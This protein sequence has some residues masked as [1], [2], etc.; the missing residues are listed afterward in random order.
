ML[1]Q[2]TERHELPALKERGFTGYLIKP[3]RAA[4]LA[5]RLTAEDAFEDMF[6]DLPAEI[7]TAAGWRSPPMRRP[8]IATPVSP[9]AWTACW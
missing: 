8:K 3:L 2:P 5:A 1:I 9:P 7:S 4:S 6:E